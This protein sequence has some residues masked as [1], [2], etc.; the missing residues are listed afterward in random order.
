[1][2]KKDSWLNCDACNSEFKVF[3]DSDDSVLFCPYCGYELEH[4]LD[5]ELEWNEDNIEE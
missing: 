2:T 4:I 1:M 5:E 3:S